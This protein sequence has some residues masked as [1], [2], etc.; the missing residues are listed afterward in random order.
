MERAACRRT[1]TMSRPRPL[2][3]LAPPTARAAVWTRLGRP[4]RALSTRNYRLYFVGQLIS[5]TGNWMQRVAQAWL[6][7]D[8]S[9]SPLALGTVAALQFL[10]ILALSLLG[11]VLADRTS[12]RTYLLVTQSCQMVLAFL[13][14]GLAV[15][16][17]VQLWHVYLVAALNGI[18]IALDQPARRALP[19][20]LVPREQVPSAVALGSTLFNSARVLGPALGGVTIVALG[21][22]GCFLLNGASYLAVLAALA[23][24]RPSEFYAVPAPARGSMLRQV[25]EGLHY[26]WRT[27]GVAFTL[28]LLGTLGTFGYNFS[29]VLPLLARYT[30]EVGAIG[31]GALNSAL[32]LGSVAGSLLAA[33][34]S[35]VSHRLVAAAAA[36]FSLLLALVAL[37]TWYELTLGLL[38]LQ[39]LSGVLFSASANTTIQLLV[40]DAL[41]GRVMGLY[42]VLFLGGTPIGSALTGALAEGWS[43]QVALFANAC[44][45]LAGVAGGV[46]YLNATRKA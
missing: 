13:L 32:G 42:N 37:S 21:A 1:A 36:V 34:Q 31:F 7:L 16:G 35:S 17:L 45:C 6:V 30:L 27:P 10:P 40:P 46:A 26:S 24:L 20:E 14:G 41:R 44:V 25:G 12:K 9:G 39:G 29:V 43:V 8:L 28:L 11:G 3:R 15:S 2:S 5:Q 23:M 19:S 38:F 33:S 18:A 4:F 22:G